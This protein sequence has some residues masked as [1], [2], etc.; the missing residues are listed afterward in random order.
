MCIHRYLFLGGD[1]STFFNIVILQL[2]VNQ[3][4]DIFV[5]ELTELDYGYNLAFRGI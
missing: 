1:I 3:K 5:F 4:C 2:Y